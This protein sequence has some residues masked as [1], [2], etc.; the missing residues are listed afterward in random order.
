MQ[1]SIAT[2]ERVTVASVAPTALE[3]YPGWLLPLG[4]SSIG[5]ASSAVPL[6]HA[7]HDPALL[8][9]IVERYRARAL[10]PQFRVADVRGLA[11]LQRSLERRQFAPARAT[12]VQLAHVSPFL[13]R[14]A[15][16]SPI[17]G[18]TQPDDAWADVYCSAGLS[19]ERS[20]Q[21][22]AAVTRARDTVYLSA[23]DRERVVAVGALSCDADIACLHGMCTAPEARGRGHAGNII[24]AAA[25]A[26]HSRGIAHVCLQVESE[27]S[28][29]LAAYRRAGFTT[30]WQYRYWQQAEA[31]AHKLYAPQTS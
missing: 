11:G 24:A 29:A 6:H 20:L 25:I 8:E 19:D 30:F 15:A 14:V 21:R 12:F 26:A 1:P 23:R 17:S 18:A 16:D 9:S 5:R 27:N 10:P 28:A 13:A 3:E 31:D 2:I 7:P 22:L 4:P